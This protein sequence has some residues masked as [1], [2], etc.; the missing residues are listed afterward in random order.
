MTKEKVSH[1]VEWSRFR[2]TVKTL[3]P[4]ADNNLRVVQRDV[5]INAQSQL[6]VQRE[7]NLST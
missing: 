3:V 1:Q 6:E 2:R 7:T 5:R 4:D